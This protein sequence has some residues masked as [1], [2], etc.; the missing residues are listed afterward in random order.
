[1]GGRSLCLSTH[2]PD[3][4][5]GLSFVPSTFAKQRDH[6]V[7]PAV[8]CRLLCAYSQKLIQPLPFQ[9]SLLGLYA[10]LVPFAGLQHQA[11]GLLLS[12]GI[13]FD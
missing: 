13:P 1:M 10:C 2:R 3:L 6:H 7:F 4:N 11:S 8:L 9:P 12:N 5:A